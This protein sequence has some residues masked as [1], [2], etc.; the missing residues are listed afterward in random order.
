[1]TSLSSLVVGFAYPSERTGIEEHII[2]IEE[3]YGIRVGVLSL[4]RLWELLLIKNFSKETPKSIDLGE[5][6]GFL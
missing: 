1:M 5:A 2:E 3:A 6:R 4:A